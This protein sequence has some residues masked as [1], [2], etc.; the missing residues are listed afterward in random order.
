MTFQKNKATDEVALDTASI[1]PNFKTNLKQLIVRL[2]CYGLIPPTFATWLIQV[3][4]LR[5]E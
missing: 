2:A 1:K 5:H 3:G 4:G